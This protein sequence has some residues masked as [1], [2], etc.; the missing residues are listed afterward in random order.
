LQID[1]PGATPYATH[2]GWIDLGLS[3]G[4]PALLLVGAILASL[5]YLGIRSS[6]PFKLTVPIMAGMIFLLYLVGELNG[7]HSIE[8]LFYWLAML[9]ALQLPQSPTILVPQSIKLS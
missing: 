7:K 5:F 1:Y 8:I 4:I 6:G 9:T 2:S 3:F